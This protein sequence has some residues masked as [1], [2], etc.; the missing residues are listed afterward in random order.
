MNPIDPS[1]N[2]LEAML[3]E[4]LRRENAPENFSARVLTRVAQNSFTPNAQ[5]ESW[6]HI[7]SQPLMRWA[8]FAAISFCLIAGGVRYRHLQHERAQGEAAKHQ[9]MLALRIAGTKLHLAKS[10]VNEI[11]T[12]RPQSE[13]RRRT[14]R[15]QS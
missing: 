11:N 8:A 15:S 14:P 7:L 13:P 9:L 1:S 10:K 3:K 5:K 12:T 6:L 2:R 4:A